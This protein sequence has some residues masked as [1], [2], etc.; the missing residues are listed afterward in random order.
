MCQGHSTLEYSWQKDGTIIVKTITNSIF[1]EKL[2]QGCALKKATL[3][4]AYPDFHPAEHIFNYS[5]NTSPIS[6]TSYHSQLDKKN[7]QVL[8]RLQRKKQIQDTRQHHLPKKAVRNTGT[9]NEK[10]WV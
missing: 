10:S 9:S 6:Q 5:K 3:S 4:R 7:H 8:R 2:F 1:E